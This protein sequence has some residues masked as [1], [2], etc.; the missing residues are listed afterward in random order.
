MILKW[1]EISDNFQ[2]RRES[3]KQQFLAQQR[4]HTLSGGEILQPDV[5]SRPAYESQRTIAPHSRPMNVT[6]MPSSDKNM[7][8]FQGI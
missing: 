5:Y 2:Q 7:S 1:Q 4:S 6:M 3:H 8:L